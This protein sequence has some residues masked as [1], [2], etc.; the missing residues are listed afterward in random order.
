MRA[1]G[2]F[3]LA[4]EDDVPITAEL[5]FGNMNFARSELKHLPNVYVGGKLTDGRFFLKVEAAQGEFTYE[6]R[7]TDERMATQNPTLCQTKNRRSFRVDRFN[8]LAVVPS[9]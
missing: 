4:G 3:L 6:A 8:A 2:L 1:D 5:N 7:R 9:S